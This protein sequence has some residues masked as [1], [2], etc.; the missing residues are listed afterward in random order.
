MLKFSIKKWR[1]YVGVGVCDYWYYNKVGYNKFYVSKV[2]YFVNMVVDE[3]I[4]YY[5]V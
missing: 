3:V 1:G 4:E 2:V 5:E